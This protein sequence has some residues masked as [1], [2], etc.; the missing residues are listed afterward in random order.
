M[1][2]ITNMKR[3]KVLATGKRDKQSQLEKAQVDHEENAKR[4]KLEAKK[5]R[6]KA[7][8]AAKKALEP[9]TGLKA[10]RRSL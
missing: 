1:E 2:I 3:E 5:E 8:Q 7:I 9:N 6:A 4:E 10:K